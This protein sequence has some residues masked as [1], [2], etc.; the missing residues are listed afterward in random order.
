MEPPNIFAA[1]HN[2]FSLPFIFD[3]VPGIVENPT[4]RN[5]GAMGRVLAA[6]GPKGSAVLGRPI[7]NLS[8]ALNY[9]VGGLDVRGYHVLNLAIHWLAGLTLFGIVRRTL[10]MSAPPA[11][12]EQ[13]GPPPAQFSAAVRSD[14]TILALTIALLWTVHPLQTE[15]V[16]AT[17]QR[18]ES[19]MGLF[20][21]L[22]LYCF[23]RGAANE[24]SVLGGAS[25]LPRSPGDHQKTFRRGWSPAF[26]SRAVSGQSRWLGAS[27][28]CFALGMASKEVMVSAPL[29]VFLYDR[30]FISGSFREAWRRRAGLYCALACTWALLA[31]LVA[32]SGGQRGGTVG[33]GLGISVWHYF[34]TQC[35][36]IVLYLRLSLWPHP[37]IADYGSAFVL[38]PAEV[39]PQIL[40][41][42]LLAAGTLLLI[43]RHPKA[44]FIGA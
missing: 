44:G 35:R 25:A 10:A 39:L 27:I 2:G 26:F 7:V 36:A 42:T 17:I 24:E 34:L 32:T 41:L 8:L 4:I 30:T 40:L 12:I 29:I 19:L 37:L 18:T 23:I 3:D 28:A 5:L 21:L 20:Y 31:L 9:A 22:T 1:Y 14:A 33:F 13:R 43:W 15:T 11:G 6:S 16:D 38:N